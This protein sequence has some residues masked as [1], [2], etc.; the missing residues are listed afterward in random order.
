MW[1]QAAG[2]GW[3]LA[4]ELSGSGCCTGSAGHWD[5]RR[6]LDE[7]SVWDE[8]QLAAGQRR[9]GW[10]SS[11]QD[12]SFAPA[13]SDSAPSVPGSGLT[14]GTQWPASMLKLMTT[15]SQDQLRFSALTYKKQD[16]ISG[17][18]CLT[19][20][21]AVWSSNTFCSLD[22]TSSLRA[23]ELLS[24]WEICSSKV[25]RHKLTW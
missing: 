3:G 24:S 4:P 21:I 16:T 9:P 22:N 19:S 15:Q 5:R 13:G 1:D 12:H 11:A 2:R 10:C 8:P 7:V 6:S 14:A 20:F 18:A 25:C 23:W 17:L